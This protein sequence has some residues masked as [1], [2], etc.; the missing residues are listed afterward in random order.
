MF[1]AGLTDWSLTARRT[2]ALTEVVL[3]NRSKTSP[4]RNFLMNSLKTR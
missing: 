1:T 2:L 3:A 4:E